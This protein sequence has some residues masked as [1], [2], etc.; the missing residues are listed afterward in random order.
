MFGRLPPVLGSR[1]PVLGRLIELPVEGLK[2][3]LGRFTGVLGR[4]V[5]REIL[6][7]PPEGRCVG[8]EYE[9]LGALPE[10]RETL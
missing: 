7:D 2:L 3:P 5:G 6:F 4:G 1:L 8:L 9:G 10:L